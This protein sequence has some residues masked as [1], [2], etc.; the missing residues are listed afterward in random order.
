MFEASFSLAFLIEIVRIGR[1]ETRKHKQLNFA[2][3]I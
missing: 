1:F 3:T 2:D